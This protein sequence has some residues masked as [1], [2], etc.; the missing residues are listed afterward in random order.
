[1]N[2]K[3]DCKCYKDYPLADHTTLKIGG[4]A[5]MAF[6]PTSVDELLDL[7]N[8]LTEEGVQITIIG[9][10]SN[11]LV[12]SGG[13]S[14]AVIFTKGLDEFEELEDGSIRVGSGMK[15]VK[16]AKLAHERELTGLEFLIG[17]PGTIGGA[18][19][20]NSSAHGQAIKD[21]IESVRVL[22]ISTGEVV[23][24]DKE[25]LELDYRSSFV[26]HNKHVILDATFR[27]EK[28]ESTKI[29]ELMEFHVNYR[30]QNHPPYTDP[31][32]GSTFRNPERGVY[33]G[34]MFEELGLKGH[35][36][37]GA[38]LSTKHA[39]FVIN[40]GNATSVDISRLMHKMHSGVKEKYGYD[41]IAEIRY[42]GDMSQEEEEIWKNFQ[43]H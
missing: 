1:M 36:E 13:V 3:L 9:A 29:S 39:N 22:N 28:G 24:L 32:A 23:N 6:F 10:G 42:V 27:L 43:V 20:M 11:L 15:S 14:G 30:M 31:S 35:K 8:K 19:T 4:N 17:I 16:L 21:V 26:Q 33:V 2:I 40:N 18:V 25:Q 38:V 34:K 7:R 5:Q 41:L 12:S 37:G